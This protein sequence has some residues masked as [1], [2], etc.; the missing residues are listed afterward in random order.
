M[1]PNLATLVIQRNV[2]S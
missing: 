1:F 2:H